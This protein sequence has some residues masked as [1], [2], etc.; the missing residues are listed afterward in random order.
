[1][2]PY[3]SFLLQPFAEILSTFT[4]LSG[5]DVRLWLSVIKCLKQSFHFDDGGQSKFSQ[6]FLPRFLTVPAVVFLV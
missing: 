2:T 1:M 4:N 3:M 5:H 6:S